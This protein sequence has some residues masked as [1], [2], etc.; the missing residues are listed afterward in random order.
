MQKTH[1]NSLFAVIFFLNCFIAFAKD[2]LAVLPF[3]GGQGEDGETIAELFMFDPTINGAF[4]LIPRT[5]I[6]RA[7]RGEQ[8]F[9]MSG[10]MTDPD[11]AVSLG[12]ELGARYVIA[13]NIARLGTQNLLVIGIINTETLEQIAGDIQTFSKIEEMPGKLPTMAR[14]IA[15]ATKRDSSKLPK[16]AATRVVISG[17]DEA[18]DILAQILTVYLVQQGSYAIYPRTRSLDQVQDEWK[19]QTSGNTA[20]KNIVRIGAGE[21]PGY[22]L[23]CVARKLGAQTMFNA[24]I[25]NLESGVQNTGSSVN[26]TSLN[27]GIEVMKKLAANL[28]NSAKTEFYVNNEA[29]LNETINHINNRETGNY[30]IIIN[31]NISINSGISSINGN[32]KTI[33]IT[34]DSQMRTITQNT[35]TSMFSVREEVNLILG[36]N[37]TLNGNRKEYNL[38]WVANN[39]SLELQGNVIL[40]NARHVCVFVYEGIFTM[41]GG[42][43]RGNTVT[44]KRTASTAE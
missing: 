38:I 37:L 39:G 1:L 2:N 11:K 44:V 17:S 18:G 35:D 9:Q 4:A 22:A 7:M 19:N 13:G 31:G 42:T 10:G 27:D 6:T 25:I 5:S 21:N 14:N 28:S 43:I 23:S 29:Q 16:L 24:S 12:R 26:Y 41:N 8:A 36:N 20:D 32:K 33:T 40:Q 3:S 30:S 15:A 34:G